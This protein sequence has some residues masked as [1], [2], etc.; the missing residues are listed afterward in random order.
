MKQWPPPVERSPA[1]VAT[2]VSRPNPSCPEVMMT[3]CDW[4]GEEGRRDI[5]G[6]K[7]GEDDQLLGNSGSHSSSRLA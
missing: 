3:G 1:R 6:E 2:V 7:S 5:G 4:V